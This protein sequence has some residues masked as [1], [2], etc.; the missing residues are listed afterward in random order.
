MQVYDL[1]LSKVKRRK[2]GLPQHHLL[3]NE[4]NFSVHHVGVDKIGAFRDPNPDG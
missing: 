2:Y 4:C 3:R 1:L